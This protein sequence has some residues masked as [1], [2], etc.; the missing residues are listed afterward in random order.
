MISANMHGVTQINQMARREYADKA[1]FNNNFVKIE[2]TV[3]KML[4]IDTGARNTQQEV[5]PSNPP[6]GFKGPLS[7]VT[8]S[9]HTQ[10]NFH[11]LASKSC[12]R[13]ANLTHKRSLRAQKKVN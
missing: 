5:D 12:N 2:K 7:L 6:C 13:I 3:R 10:P 9:H 4:Q 1:A 8:N 11:G